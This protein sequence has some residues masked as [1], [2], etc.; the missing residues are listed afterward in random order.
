[1][2]FETST[3]IRFAHVDAAGITFYPRYFEMLN[4]AIEDWF[5]RVLGTSF[6]EMHFERGIGVPTVQLSVEF[7]SPST[8]GDELTICIV[9][10]HVG[11]TSCA[12][13]ALFTA[14]GRDRLKA[15]A[16]LVCMQ[17]EMQKSVPWPDDIRLRMMDEL[18]MAS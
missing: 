1:M 10:T 11:R 6:H 7:F 5:A 17:L 2:A 18:A 12:Y 15:S 9:P 4:G 16:T 3:Q 8:L 14:N 13:D